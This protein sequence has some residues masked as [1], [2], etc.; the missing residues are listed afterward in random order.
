LS[1]RRSRVRVSSAPPNLFRELGHFVALFLFCLHR[2]R[3]WRPSATGPVGPFDGM[4]PSVNGT[5]GIDRARK[6]WRADVVVDGVRRRKRFPMSTPESVIRNWI[7]RQ[8]GGSSVPLPPLAP[9]A[10]DLWN[11]RWLAFK[12][13]RRLPP[14][15]RGISWTIHGWRLQVMNHC[16]L[17][18][19]SFPKHGPMEE[20]SGWLAQHRNCNPTV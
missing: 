1:R 19:R 2:N 8:L 10:L 4:A 16:K 17:S 6:Q 7:A 5:I 15:A 9:S 11:E 13:G 18:V 12:E 14:P 3:P 20:M